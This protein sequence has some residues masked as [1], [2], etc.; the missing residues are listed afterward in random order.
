MFSFCKSLTPSLFKAFWFSFSD[1][2]S[3]FRFFPGSDSVPLRRMRHLDPPALPPHTTMPPC[4][5]VLPD[6]RAGGTES[7]LRALDAFRQV[8]CKHAGFDAHH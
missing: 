5:M 6:F 4:W 2:I 3:R 1:L 8:T 7:L